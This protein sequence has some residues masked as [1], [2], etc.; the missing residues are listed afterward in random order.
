MSQ[1]Y[2]AKEAVSLAITIKDVVPELPAETPPA[3]I[4]S[5]MPLLE[6]VRVLRD[7]KDYGGAA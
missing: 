1:L 5:E 2:E 3:L 6:H 7:R 4:T